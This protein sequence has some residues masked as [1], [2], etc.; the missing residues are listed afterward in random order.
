MYEDM[1]YLIFESEEDARA[2]LQN[3][4]KS[5]HICTGIEQSEAGDIQWGFDQ[6]PTFSPIWS[7][8]RS[9]IRYIR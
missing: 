9:L 6:M 4:L 2:D 3:S 8:K 7:Y 1:K 5:G